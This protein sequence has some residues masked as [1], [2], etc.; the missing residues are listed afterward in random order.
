MGR[1]RILATLQRFPYALVWLAE[2]SPHSFLVGC[3]G[4]HCGVMRL[5]GNMAGE[6]VFW[7]WLLAKVKVIQ[8]YICERMPNVFALPLGL[9][10][11]ALGKGQIACHA[12]CWCVTIGGF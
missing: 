9:N 6:S 8:K 12:S 10:I 5:L 1:L 2:R 4:L 11:P 3:V 7:R